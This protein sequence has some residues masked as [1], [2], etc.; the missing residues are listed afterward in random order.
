MIDFEKFKPDISGKYSP[1]LYKWLNHKHQ[2]AFGRNFVFQC[3]N[4]I[5][6]NGFYDHWRH[7][8]IIIGSPDYHEDGRIAGISG[9]CLRDII[10][11]SH[12]V[13]TQGYYYGA[14]FGLRDITS[15]FWEKYEKHGRCAWDEKHQMHMVGDDN[16]WNYISGGKLRECN[17]CGHIQEEIEGY[18]VDY[19]SS[20]PSDILHP[21]G[22]M[23]EYL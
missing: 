20:K 19:K 5:N 10:C 12:R 1:L 3:H 14:G 9:R 21:M 6:G 2:K 22:S 11:G 4:R 15:E 18:W 8:E 13:N 7:L 16:R 23:G 17:W